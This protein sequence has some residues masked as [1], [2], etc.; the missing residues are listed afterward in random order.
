MKRFLYLRAV[1]A[2]VVCS[3]WVVPVVTSLAN[4]ANEIYFG[5][6]LRFERL[7]VEDGLPNATVLSVLQDRDGFMWFATAD[8]VARYDGTEFKVFRHSDDP[9][10]LSNNNTFCLLQSRDGLIWIGTDP[11]GLNVYDPETGRFSVFRNDPADPSSLADNSVWSLMEDNEGNIWVGTR[12]GLSRLDRKTGKF[13]NYAVD[14]ANPRALAHPVVYRIYQDRAGTIWVGTR[15]GLQRYQPATDDFDTFQHDP[16]NPASISSSNVWSM[17]EDSQGNF[18][19]GT[20]GGGLNLMDRDTGT[21]KA[22]RFDENDPT[23]LSSDRVWFVFED[24]AGRLWVATETAG[25]NL[26]D[27]QNGTFT[28]YHYNPGDLFSLSNDD[29]YWI[30]ED[31]SGALWFAS[32]YGGVNKLS[33]MMQRFGLYRNIPGDS[34]SLSSSNVYSVLAESD[35]ILWVGTFGGGL[36]RIDRR[37]EEVTVFMNNPSDPA[38][39]SHNKVYYIHRDPR[40]TLWL[41]TAGGGLNRMNPDGNTFTAYKHVEGDPTSLSSNFLTTIA[42]A[43][44]GRLWIGTLGLGLDLF[45]PQT[46]KVVKKYTHNPANS[47]SLGEDTIYDLEVDQNGQVW[48]A[49]ARGGLN[50]LNPKNDSVIRYLHNPNDKNSILSDTVH[51]LYLDEANQMLWAATP[52]GLSGLNL[53]T[54]AWQ[55]YTSQDGLPTNTIV[56]VLPDPNGD[57]WISTGKGISHFQISTRTFVNYDARDGLQSDQFGI[58]AAHASPDGE[59]FFGGSAGLTYFHAEQIVTNPYPPSVVF[60]DFQLFNQSVPPGS[61]LLPQ[62]IEKTK[63]ISLDYNQSVFTFKFAALSYQIPSKN[64][65]QYKMVGFDNDWSPARPINQATY[66]NLAPGK[67][68]FMVHASNHDG[69]WCETPAAIEIEIRPPWWGT[70]WFRLGAALTILA[71]IVGGV[72]WRINS[73]RAINRELEKRVA[74]R[75][76]ELQE[77]KILLEN[78]NE[79]LRKQ[80]KIITAL[81]KKLREQALHDALTGL[82]NRHHLADVLSHEFARANRTQQAIALLLIDLDRFKSINDRYGHTAGDLVLKETSRVIRQQI[83]E[84]DSAFRY[85]GEEFLLVLPEITLEAALARAEQIRDALRNLKIT[86]NGETIPVRCSIGVSIYPH[87]GSTSDEIL[88]HAD[89]ALYRAKTLGGDQV[90]LCR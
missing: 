23:S 75:T 59:L 32:R 85:G 74:E 57:L 71:L 90:I 76:R 21:F 79:A 37:T 13:T 63:K 60:T 20:R 25:V 58:A 84:S 7:S 27:R 81:Q 70:W 55:N 50:L 64:L 11:G 56:G 41:A 29:I 83:R 5:P 34:R 45:D 89:Q 6:N 14:P 47:N 31:R 61:D 42:D 38:S 49:T 39:I 44:D 62:P 65:Y 40:G 18:W 53:R 17:L 33:P 22:Y 12:N 48:I 88:N 16:N 9:N 67:Y 78:A 51:A 24:S 2:A 86:Y 72:Q 15:N 82:Y 52:E 36:N 69:I 43:A 73:I 87:H 4:S 19:V 35:G 46:G 26:F 80:I 68:T 66:T 1:V 8:G 77:A 3:L 30:A 28:R 10:S 54:G